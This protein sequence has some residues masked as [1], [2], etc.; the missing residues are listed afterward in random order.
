MNDT[1]LSFLGTDFLHGFLV[2]QPERCRT[3][4][5]TEGHSWILHEVTVNPTGQGSH[6][7]SINDSG[8]SQE[9][10]TQLWFGEED[11]VPHHY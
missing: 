11:H 10:R 1:L 4:E 5:Q 3:I 6:D 9:Q 8:V 2:E 7:G